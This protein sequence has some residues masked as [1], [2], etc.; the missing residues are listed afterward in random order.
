MEHSKTAIIDIG[1]NTV[2]LVIYKEQGVGIEEFRNVKAPLRL[3]RFLDE[4]SVMSNEGIAL[5]LEAMKNFREVL[6]YYDVTEVE[7]T[8]T[9][10]IRQAKNSDEIIWKVKEE[11]AFQIRLLS[12]EEEALYG[13]S[14]VLKTMT[15]DN[16]LTID[17]GG[18]STEITLFENRKLKYSYSFPFGVVSLKQLFIAEDRMKPKEQKR[19]AEYIQSEL[20]RYTWLQKAPDGV[21]AA[22]GGSARNLAVVQQ[23]KEN[24]P[25][26]GVHGYDL[27]LDALH[28]LREELSSLSYAELG[29]VDGLSNERSDLILPA[30]EVFYQLAVHTS[31]NGLIVSS[32]GLRDGIMLERIKG[33]QYETAED[34]K[35]NGIKRLLKVYGHDDEHHH[36]MMVLMEKM[37]NGFEKEGLLN[38]TKQ[39]RF[40]IEQSAA[41]FYLGEYISSS[42][43]SRH[44]FYLLINSLFDGFTH[45]EKAYLSLTASF[46]NNSTLKQYLEEFNG[47]FTKEEI[48]KMREYG[49]LL[50]LCYSLNSSKRS[51][52]QDLDVKEK[53]NNILITVYCEGNE[54]A[55]RYQSDKQKRQLEKALHKEITL[56]FKQK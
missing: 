52:V 51:V 37:V 43:K 6:D 22:I 20:S 24:Y 10:A 36:Q 31:A 55:E 3:N 42:S 9:A 48:Q 1:S 47:W 50:K 28:R 23:L 12:G 30:I 16:G 40:I 14:A 5:L 2:R 8:A 34:V 27:T 25:P 4:S 39:E 17:I 41:L 56:Q 7:C 54:M 29:K 21:I 19:M 38:V 32:R 15:P 26:L 45:S 18:G 11:T 53:Q 33:E 46:T 44:T 35:R 49:A 13:L